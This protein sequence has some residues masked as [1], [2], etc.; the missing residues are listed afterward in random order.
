MDT[1]GAAYAAAGQFREAI[2]TAEKAIELAGIAGQPK[3]AAECEARLELYRNGRAYF[4]PV[5]EA[6]K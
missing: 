6:D 3:L 1:L 4:Q 2:A 5:G